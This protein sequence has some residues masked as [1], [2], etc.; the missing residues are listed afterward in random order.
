MRAVA[1]SLGL[2]LGRERDER[3]G[4]R[5]SRQPHQ[6][7]NVVVTGGFVEPEATAVDTPVDEDPTALAA[8]RDRDRLHA[9]GAIG[10]AVTWD[11]AVEMT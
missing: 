2:G 5:E 8:D 1:V 10:L 3:H 11:V 6:E 4:Q 7:Q 9:A